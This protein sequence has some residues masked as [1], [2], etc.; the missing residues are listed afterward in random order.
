[1]V[2]SRSF[3][4]LLVSAVLLAPPAFA[5]TAKRSS[6]ASIHTSAARKSSHGKRKSRR[7]R[8]QQAIEPDRVT[9]IQQALIR[10][11][12]LTGEANG[13]WDATT[14][15]AM[16]KYQA[17]HGWQTKLMPDSR[18]LKSLGL[19]A[20]YS[21]AINAQG[22]NFVPPPASDAI[23]ASQTAGFTAASGVKQ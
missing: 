2:L 21:G 6:T 10:E 13:K 17:D 22:L 4:A 3:L 19:G 5:A 23:P 7:P 1:V 20:D 12:Y 8:G 16:Q 15:A 9:Q 11:H 18:A 14:I